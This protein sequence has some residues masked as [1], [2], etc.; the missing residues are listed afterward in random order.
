MKLVPSDG[1]RVAHTGAEITGK[2]REN[3]S[4]APA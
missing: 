4:E 2:R 1:K 3:N